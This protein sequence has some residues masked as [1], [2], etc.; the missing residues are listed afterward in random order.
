MKARRRLT[1]RSFLE[2][3]WLP[4]IKPTVRDSTFAGYE[5]HVRNHIAPYIGDLP[6]KRLAAADLTEMSPRLL[7]E[8]HARNGGGLSPATVKRVHATMHRS[9][10]A[11]VKWDLIETNPADKADP[12]RQLAGHEMKTWSATQLAHFLEHVADDAWRDLWMLLA[13]TGLR[14]GEALGL[15]WRDVDTTRKTLAVRQCFTAVGYET[16]ITPPKTA[17]GRRVVALDDA[18]ASALGQRKRAVDQSGDDDFVFAG[19]DG[20]PPHP[21]SISKRFAQLIRETDLPHIRLHDL[22]HT[23]ATLAL[24]AGVHPKVVSE[25]LGHATVALTLDVY[26]HALEHMQHDA[27]AKVLSLILEARETS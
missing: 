12:P 11:A 8:G 22:R 3:K 20:E 18:T 24:E 21:V 26:S 9:L 23:H 25:R 17:R 15:R 5:N 6:L 14:R 19:A 1:L 13:T 10:G 16:A 2:D 27:A 4:G 7:Q